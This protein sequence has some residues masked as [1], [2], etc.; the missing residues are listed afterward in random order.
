MMQKFSDI[1][2]NANSTINMLG[3]QAAKKTEEESLS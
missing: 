1:G 3:T 2:R